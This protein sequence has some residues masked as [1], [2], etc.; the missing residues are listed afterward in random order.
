M[1]FEQEYYE[2]EGFWEGNMISDERNMTRIAQT[3]GLI[4]SDCKS[5]LDVGC[6]NGRFVHKILETRSDLKVIATDRSLEA[7]QYVQCE[8]FISSIENIGVK[9]NYVDCVSCLEVLEH[10]HDPNYKKSLDELARVSSKYLLIS[11][12]YKENLID[13]LTQCPKCSCSF[14][15]ELHMRS[16]DEKDI[17]N[18]FEKSGY[19][20]VKKLNIIKSK[21]LLGQ[22][23]LN[24]IKKNIKVGAKPEFKSPICVVCGYKPEKK[25]ILSQSVE[26]IIPSK[27]KVNKGLINIIKSIWPKINAEGYWIIA[28]YQKK[29]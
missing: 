26:N 5:L 25:F 28:L 9:D 18:M 1:T 23:I 3:I 29:N 20:L 24:K 17:D 15:L 16:Y 13:S 6:G 10:I 4:P 12:P 11:V 19:E 21:K 2:A 27:T 22:S 14:N 7:M 8:K